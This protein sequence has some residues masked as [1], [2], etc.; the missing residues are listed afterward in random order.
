[1]RVG[2]EGTLSQGV[3]AFGMR[4]SRN[5]GLVEIGLQQACTGATM[6]V[7][8][9]VSGLPERPFAKSGC[10]YKPAGQ[11]L[12]R[13]RGSALGVAI[14]SFLKISASSGPTVVA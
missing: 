5:V 13:Q 3:R 12:S 10:A 8:R 4:R 9:A 1:M 7:S 14:W 6:N 11:R 2:V